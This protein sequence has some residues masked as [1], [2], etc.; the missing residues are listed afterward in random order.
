MAT[1]LELAKLFGYALL[2]TMIFVIGRE[3]ISAWGTNQHATGFAVIRAEG[4][5]VMLIGFFTIVLGFVLTRINLVAG[6]D[7][8]PRFTLR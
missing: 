1:I 7:G 6:P 4:Y 8:R 5:S 2:M 3:I